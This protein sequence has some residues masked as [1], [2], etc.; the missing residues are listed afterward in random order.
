MIKKVLALAAGALFSLNAS[1]GYVQYNFNGPVTGFF[2]QH[3]D[4][5]SIAYYAFSLPYGTGPAGN[6]VGN[7]FR[8]K[9]GS[10]SDKITAATTYFRNNGPTNFTLFDDYGSQPGAQEG[11]VSLDFSRATGGDFSYT[12]TFTA[13]LAYVGE[14]GWESF[15]YSGQLS[16]LVTK[17]AADP[18]MTQY[19]DLMGGYEI[20]VTKIV[21]TYIDP[22][23]VPEPASLALLAVG[24]LGVGAARRRKTAC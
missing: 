5:Q 15:H 19:F 16:G 2:V 9:A 24:A 7:D 4:D 11:T 13:R 6:T 17:V 18:V 10:G 21:P 1:A 12:A 8:P 23:N 14:N 20:G 22:S 3:D